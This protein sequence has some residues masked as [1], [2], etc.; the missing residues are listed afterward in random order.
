[1]KSIFTKLSTLILCGAF[2]MVGCSDFSADLKEL[3]GK[4][5][6]LAATSATKAQ[7]TELE[8]AIKDLNEKLVEQYA[9]IADVEAVIT[10]VEGVQASLNEAKTNL[11]AAIDTKADKTELQ[12]AVDGITD[13]LNAAKTQIEG[14]LGELDS[15]IKELAEK[16]AKDLETLSQKV[17]GDI[18]TL[19]QNLEGQLGELEGDLGDL[20]GDL[21]E[22]EGTVGTL[23]TS[24]NNVMKDVEDLEGTLT[25]HHDAFENYKKEVSDKFDQVSGEIEEVSESLTK[26]IDELKEQMT[27]KADAELVENVTNLQNALSGVNSTLSTLASSVAAKADKADIQKV[28]TE[29][30]ADIAALEKVVKNWSDKDTV[31][32]DTELRAAVSAATKEYKSLVAD[33]QSQIDALENTL[34]GIHNELSGIQGELNDMKTELRS[35]V[36]VPQ[37]MYNGT[38]AVKFH[39]IE[40]ENVLKTYADVSYHF[41]P[42]NFDAT[43][44]TYEIVAEPVEFITKAIFA[45]DP[46]IEIVGSPVQENGKVTF[47]LER[48]DGTGNMFALKVTLEDGCVI[49]S[50]YTAILDEATYCIATATSSFQVERLAFNFPSLT[51]IS[52]IIEYVQSLGETIEDFESTILAIQAAVEAMQNNDIASA[53]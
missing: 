50:D 7:V 38:K 8:E 12:A 6:D 18:E 35:V 15:D 25:Q 20:E 5:E 9:T 37:T 13:A 31:Y 26:Q 30:A 24:L 44:A 14:Q 39:R 28:E 42:A 22:L 16:V 40:G 51:S 21:G 52:A 45:E 34:E 48:G 3:N 43:K 27:G 41:N 36:A 29:L 11:Q 33:L 32:D 1:M 4:L 17:A 47:H 23:Q 49:Y 46:A 19:K 10:T 53:I 2:A